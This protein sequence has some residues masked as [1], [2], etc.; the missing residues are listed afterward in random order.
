MSAAS[1]YVGWDS[2]EVRAYQACVASMHAH[3]WPTGIKITPLKSAALEL[4]GLL[5]RPVSRIMGAERNVQMWDLISNAPMSTEFANSR[6][7]T[8]LLAQTGWA[9]FVDCDVI[10][11]EDVRRL[12]ELADPQYAVMCVKHGEFE[13]A[14]LKMDGQQQ[15]VYPC[16]NW[17]SVVLFNCDH[18]ANCQLDLTKI[19]T[20]P[21]RDLHR[22]CWLHPSLIG[23]LPAE[24]NWLVGVE[25]CPKAAKLAHF[26]L[27]GPWLPGWTAKP[28]DDLWLSNCGEHPA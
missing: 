18:P 5:R 12:F 3:T 26:T 20:L 24:W 1:V 9:L 16:K 11:L 25:P 6:F 19:N 22:F 13:S 14:G 28:Y 21:G 23:E 8:P 15:R 17:S 4:A 7:L 10:F 2:R 27:G